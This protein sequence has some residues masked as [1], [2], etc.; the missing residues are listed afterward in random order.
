MKIDAWWDGH[1]TGASYHFTELPEVHPMA[2]GI[3]LNC[4]RIVMVGFLSLI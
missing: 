3:Q 4:P 1:Q 2:V